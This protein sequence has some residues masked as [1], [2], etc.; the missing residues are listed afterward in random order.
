MDSLNPIIY[1][2]QRVDQCWPSIRGLAYLNFEKCTR[3]QLIATVSIIVYEGDHH[4]ECYIYDGTG[5]V[6]AYI[7]KQESIKLE[8]G[9]NYYFRK[10]HVVVNKLGKQVILAVKTN[11][12]SKPDI[13]KYA[14]IVFKDFKYDDE[15]NNIGIV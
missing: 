14:P 3:I 8:E 15:L 10:L 5:K 12:L 6:Y 13:K 2:L 4:Y 11:E 1:S 7:S 9:K